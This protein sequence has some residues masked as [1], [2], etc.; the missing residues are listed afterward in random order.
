MVLGGGEK[1]PGVF[2]SAVGIVA[3]T[4]GPVRSGS[5]GGFDHDPAVE[6]A[7]DTQGGGLLRCGCETGG[8]D[9]QS[10]R[11]EFDQI[12]LVGVPPDELERV[13][14]P[15]ERVDALGP[16]EE[17]VEPLVVVPGAAEHGGRV[18]RPVDVGVIPVSDLGLVEVLEDEGQIGVEVRGGTGG[19]EC[20]HPD[21]L[22][23]RHGRAPGMTPGPVEIGVDA[24]RR[25]SDG[26][27]RSP[28]R[29]RASPARTPQACRRRW[30][31]W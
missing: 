9:R 16:A 21:T 30:P 11:A 28:C 1:R 13:D 14:Q 8:H 19:D 18:T 29:R 5:H 27:L 7:L 31:Q 26:E 22:R 17:L 12:P 23:P 3:V 6:C 4:G 20:D 24:A 25:L 2:F 15:C 10:A